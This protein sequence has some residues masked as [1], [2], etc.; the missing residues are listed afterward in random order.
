MAGLQSSQKLKV[1][2]RIYH[3]AASNVILSGAKNFSNNS[4]IAAER[5]QI[6]D[7]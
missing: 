3:N 6:R 5:K 1:A 4:Q 7:V 2:E